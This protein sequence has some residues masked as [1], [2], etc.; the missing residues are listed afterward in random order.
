MNKVDQRKSEPRGV[1]GATLPK[2]YQ[3]PHIAEDILGEIVGK[4]EEMRNESRMAIRE[5][6]QVDLGASG[7]GIQVGDDVDLASNERDREFSLLMR[8]RHLRRIQQ[9]DEA[10]DR[11]EE[12]TYG[13]CEGT[14][15]PINLRRLQI[16]PL[17]RYSLEYQQQ[18]ERMF[19]RVRDTAWSE[20]G[21]EFRDD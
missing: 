12:G 16:M 5:Q 15:E 9:I 21:E 18:Q 13:L 20:S 6:L 19:G 2:I 1:G 7:K 8:Q 14:E 17:A 11:M 4:L 10:F 3:L